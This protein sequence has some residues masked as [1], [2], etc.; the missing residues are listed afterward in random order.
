[1][2]S[3]YAGFWGGDDIQEDPRG[4]ICSDTKCQIKKIQTTVVLVYRVP[5]LLK[6]GFQIIGGMGNQAE[7]WCGRSYGKGECDSE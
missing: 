6:V 7:R 1:M 4:S 2:S 5:V 3:G